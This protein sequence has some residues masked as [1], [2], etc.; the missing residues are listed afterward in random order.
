MKL[1][2]RAKTPMQSDYRPDLDATSELYT[3]DITLFQELIGQLI[4]ATEIVRVDMLHEVSVLSDFQSAP[5][6]G[7][8]HQVFHIFSFMKNKPKLTT[9]FDPRLPNI[10]PTSFSGSSVEEF[11]EKYRYA[12][13]QLPKDIPE[14]RGKSVSITA[15][16]DASHASDKKTIR[17]HTGYM[18]FVNRSPIVFYSKRTV[19][20]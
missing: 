20:C 11:R 5:R 13:E 7:N 2:A 6:E 19:N 15:F 10:D 12:M 1:P 9:Y 17:S 14:P 3:N 8:L 18:V 16:V 4:W